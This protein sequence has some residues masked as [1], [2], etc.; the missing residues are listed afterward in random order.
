LHALFTAVWT[1]FHPSSNL[2][3]LPQTAEGA[4]RLERV[5][6]ERGAISGPTT[7]FVGER[8][9]DVLS[10]LE[11]F[12]IAEPAVSI[13]VYLASH[14]LYPS[15]GADMFRLATGD[16][17]SIN[18]ISRSLPIQEVVEILHQKARQALLVVDACYSGWGADDVMDAGART[19]PASLGQP[20]LF[21]IASSSPYSV[22]IASANE[23]V[24]RFTGALIQAISEQNGE[25]TAEDL[26]RRTKALAAEAGNPVPWYAAQGEASNFVI[27]PAPQKELQ[28]VDSAVEA[29]ASYEF[30]ASIL[31]IDDVVRDQSDFVND[32]GKRGHDVHIASSPQE[33]I[34]ALKGAYYDI[35]VIDL[36][37]VGDVPAT[38]LLSYIGTQVDP[39]SFIM[40]ASRHSRAEYAWAHLDAVFAHPNRVNSFTFKKDHID[41]TV[42]F[43]DRIREARRRIL[44]KVRG[45]ETIVP[46]ATGRVISRS[47]IDI[48]NRAPEL[49]LQTRVCIERLVEDWF[50]APLG[51]EY[52][53]GLAMESL[54]SGRSSC[55][56][57]SLSPDI[58]GLSP[59]SVTPLLLKIG[60]RTEIEEEVKRFHKYVQIG[61]PLNV[62]T[63]LVGASFAGEMG[64]LL[65][66]LLGGD[67]RDIRD[68][69]SVSPDEVMACLNSIFDPTANRRWYGS[70]GMGVGIR[71]MVYYAQKHFDRARLEI[72]VENMNRGLENADIEDRID[73]WFDERPGANNEYP[74]TL[75]HGDLHLGNIVQYDTTRYALIDYRD[76][77]LGPRTVDFATLEISLWLQASP[78]DGA[79]SR[80]RSK[81]IRE[82]VLA[83]NYGMGDEPHPGSVAEWLR[84]PCRLV[85]RCRQL[86]SA[87]CPNIDDLEY[88]SILWYAAVRRSQF[89]ATAVTRSEKLIMQCVPHAI[90]LAAQ[91]RVPG[92]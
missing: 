62:R 71:P 39:S 61:V 74:R 29:R 16:T 54:G 90:A 51:D 66:S 37:L 56:V 6:A 42:E 86:A 60:P 19:P 55:T 15:V 57:Y 64:G 26:Y 38:E 73:K 65:Y 92:E 27:L 59:T 41:Q 8:S 33:A 7:R 47:S 13:I 43:A 22:S 69:Q 68:L 36:F 30:R 89:R 34:E 11:D 82:L 45:L 50:T 80:D 18:S 14:G 40:L 5:L 58:A 78:P 91:L 88:F 23:P 76:V 44:S 3:M 49:Q 35:V 85:T 31:Y 28:D 70:V 46:L 48:R 4:S 24:T 79:S 63:D 83:M 2:R 87:N 52:V 9:G 1:D 67:Q 12:L 17:R 77:G 72:C 20:N 25:L 21:F 32:L 10:A 84:I 75:V 81:M 53:T